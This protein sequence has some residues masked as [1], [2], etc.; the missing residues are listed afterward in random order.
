[1][2]LNSPLSWRFTTIPW[3]F[4]PAE[5]GHGHAADSDTKTK[6]VQ[7]IRAKSIEDRILNWRFAGQDGVCPFRRVV[8]WPNAHFSNSF[9]GGTN[10][11]DATKRASFSVPPSPREFN[12]H[13]CLRGDLDRVEL[14][15][16]EERGQ[17]KKIQKIKKRCFRWF[18]R[19]NKGRVVQ[20]NGKKGVSNKAISATKPDRKA[21][22]IQNE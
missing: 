19:E 13:V 2:T 9:L 6:S 7:K 1:M 3:P 21:S 16:V 15:V 8:C 22:E 14:T 12:Q 11:I 20:R 4:D 18:P 17:R 5:G 10:P